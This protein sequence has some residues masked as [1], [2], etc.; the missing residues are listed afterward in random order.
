MAALCLLCLVAC[1]ETPETSAPE[2]EAVTY[3]IRRGSHYATSNP[4]KRTTTTSL[5]FEVTFDSSAVYTTTDPVNQ[6]DINKLYGV[7]D[8]GTTHQTNSARFGW[9]WYNNQLE[10]HAYT[11]LNKIRMSAYIG[12]VALGRKS[13][14]ELELGDQVYTFRLDSRQVTLPRACSGAGEGYQLYPYFGGD[15]TAPH[16]IRITIREMD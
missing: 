16:D 7:A 6:G 1:Q 3:L 12:T 9:R 10:I 2:P 8:C 5:K 14:C 15:E 13:I 4:L 11:Y